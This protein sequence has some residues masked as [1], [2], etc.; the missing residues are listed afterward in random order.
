MCRILHSTK[1]DYLTD[2][3]MEY[4]RAQLS[5]DQ[6]HFIL[7]WVIYCLLVTEKIGTQY[8]LLQTACQVK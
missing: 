7:E 1:T 2:K 4:W 8:C 6:H 3:N 5:Q